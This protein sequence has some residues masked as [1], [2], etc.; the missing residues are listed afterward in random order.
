MIYNVRNKKWIF[1]VIIYYNQFIVVLEVIVNVFRE[2]SNIKS[3][4]M[5]RES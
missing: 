4:F 1:I 2:A 5:D 3:L